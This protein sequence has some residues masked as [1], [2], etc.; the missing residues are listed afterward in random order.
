MNNFI[1]PAFRARR[2]LLAVIAPHPDD[3]ILGCG[4]LINAA[5]RAQWRVVVIALTDG[6]ASHPN[7]VRWPH[8]A[9]G[10]LR[11]AEMRR[12]L[13]RLG[14]S[15]VPLLFMGWRDG[16]LSKD[17]SV[18]R[19]RRVV[20]AIGASDV[21]VA[22]A[23]DRHPDHQ[24][25]W[26][27]AWLATANSRAKLHAYAVWARSEGVARPF[28]SAGKSAKTWAIKAHRS[29]VTNYIADDPEGFVF[30]RP[31]LDR[32]VTTA[33]TLILRGG[34]IVAAARSRFKK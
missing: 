34:K 7:S 20:N 9:L 1:T 11:R 4:L 3:D 22:S 5:R 14:A 27:I 12:A 32:L 26:K 30:T 2:P 13:D 29:Q 28:F 19:L 18:I 31:V 25:A 33:E 10:R 6:Q 24:A 8:H 21:A 16:S 23:Q 17:A 15:T